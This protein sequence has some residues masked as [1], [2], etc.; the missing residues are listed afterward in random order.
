MFKI[1]F[2]V[3]KEKHCLS[4]SFFV[5]FNEKHIFSYSF[6]FSLKITDKNMNSRFLAF[7]KLIKKNV[8]LTDIS[9]KFV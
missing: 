7:L 9:D 2:L 1:V 8:V 4:Y 6:C 3:V 5:L